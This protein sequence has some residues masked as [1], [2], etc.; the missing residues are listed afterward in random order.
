MSAGQD[1]I[2]ITGIAVMVVIIGLVLSQRRHPPVGR[3]TVP[4]G[5]LPPGAAG[6]EKKYEEEFSIRRWLT[7]TYHKDVGI[8]YLVT[9]LFFLVF[10][11]VVALTMRVQLVVP[12]NTLIPPFSYEQLVSLHGLIM[13]LWFLSPFGIAFANYF[14]PLQIGAKDLAF[15]RLNALSYWLYAFSGILLIGTL[16]AP[17]GGPGTGWTFFAPLSTTPF[18]P[19]P[20]TTLAVLALGMLSASVTLTSVNFIATVVRMRAPGVT[21]S[22]IPMFT[23]F[24]LATIALMLFA[25]PALGAGVILL[26]ADRLLNTGIFSTASS[27]IL[28]EQLFWFFGH[29]EVYIVVLPALGG[30]AAVIGTFTYRRL[31]SKKLILAGV[32]GTTLLSMLVWGHHMFT[33]GISFSVLA[34]FSGTTEAIS[35][36]FGFIALG[37]ILSLSRGKI[38]LT[39]P[40][41]FALGALF[42]LI[43][44]GITGVMQSSVTLDYALSGTYW[45]VAHFHYVMVGTSIFG[46]MAALYYWFPKITGRMYNERFGRFTFWLSFISFNILYFPYFFMY[47]M[48]RRVATY[49]SVGLQIPNT[50]A[51][52]GA[53]IFGPSILLIFYNLWRSYRANVPSGTNPWGSVEPEW[54][55]DSST[56]PAV[57]E[58]AEK[59]QVQPLPMIELEPSPANL[60]KSS[61]PLR[62]LQSSLKGGD[63][64]EGTPSF[65]PIIMSVGV[66]IIMLGLSLNYYL[67]IVGGIIFAASVAM[68]F[69]DGLGDKFASAQGTMGEM[70]PLKG[71]SSKAKV[72]IWVFLASEAVIFGAFITAYLYIRSISTTWIVSYQVHDVAIG[73]INT[74]IL[75]TSTLAIVLA[76][77][78]IRNGNVRGLKLWTAVAFIL[79]ALF[80]AIK[81]GIEWPA[82]YAN[83]FTLTSGLP[84]ATYFL[85]VGLHAVHVGI[86]LIVMAYLLAK[87]FQGKFSSTNYEAVE[88]TTIFW[89][90]IDIVW[91]FL[92]ALFYLI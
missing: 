72:G 13:I 53:F 23:W 90:F 35:I 45:I 25:F 74:V 9:S 27:T 20:G 54:T 44:G 21:W 36:P 58:T 29:P 39:T 67:A 50:V 70:W 10:G 46:L 11:G 52:V 42:M 32:A 51:T 38:K 59:D 41:L 33:T 62:Q 43:L 18:S 60:T 12:N 47:D 80:L 87:T 91:L 5:Q 8:L 2:V 64:P 56:R 24:I 68:L 65:M 31:F 79:G 73:F 48:P 17:G 86:G 57:Y 49:S 16:F 81:L 55:S 88:V 82:L 15:P 69:R 76:F 30:I 19:S 14:I 89:V 66:A 4:V 3:A 37:L 6:D 40:M 71:L 92:F 1:V 77:Y 7:T 63:K 34:F 61:S 75:L 22:K 85:T 78:S 84:A 83:G 26:S 28:W